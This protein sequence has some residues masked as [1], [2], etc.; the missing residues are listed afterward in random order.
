M[1]D[2][3]YWIAATIAVFQVLSARRGRGAGI[4]FFMLLLGIGFYYWLFSRIVVAIVHGIIRAIRA[5]IQFVIRMFVIFIIRP[6][7]LLYKLSKLIFAFL[8]AFTIFL[9]KV[10]LQLFVLFGFWLSGSYPRL[11]VRSEDGLSAGKASHA[12]DAYTREVRSGEEPIHTALASHK[13]S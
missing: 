8:L 5:I 7:Q 2:L 1:F 9:I 13:G 6:L 10:V 11:F 3:L 4:H 12:K